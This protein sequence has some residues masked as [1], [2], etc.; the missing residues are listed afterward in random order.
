MSRIQLIVVKSFR[1]RHCEQPPKSFFGRTPKGVG[2][3][4]LK[5]PSQCR[6]ASFPDSAVCIA[7][8]VLP[9]T[10]FGGCSQR[11]TLKDFTTMSWIRDIWLRKSRATM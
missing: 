3:L 11:L 4:C 8:G 9:K 2:K 7:F 6:Q 10:F 1:V 5:F